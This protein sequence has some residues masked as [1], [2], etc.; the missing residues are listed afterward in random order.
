[1]LL[2]VSESFSGYASPQTLHMFQ[3]LYW[4]SFPWITSHASI[5]S[6]LFSHIKTY[7]V[8][9][10]VF[11]HLVALFSFSYGKYMTSLDGCYCLLIGALMKIIS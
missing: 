11:C 9:H 2:S 7:R 4:V 8:I 3:F 5:L 6:H 10:F 1:M